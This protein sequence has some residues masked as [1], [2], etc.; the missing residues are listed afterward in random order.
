MGARVSYRDLRTNGL[1]EV[2]IVFPEEAN[3]A[4]G[5][6]SVLAPVGAALIGLS[7]GQEIPWHFPDGS[8][9]RLRVERVTRPAPP[10][11][12]N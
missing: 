9:H 11:E 2:E 12:S 8:V 7:V 3:P 5:R 4:A 1:R 10:A 6:V